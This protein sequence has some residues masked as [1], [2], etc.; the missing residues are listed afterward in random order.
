MYEVTCFHCVNSV[1]I[2]PDASLCPECGEDLQHLLA[3]EAVVHYFQTRAH[4]LSTQGQLTTALAEAER[5]LTFVPASELRLLAAILAKQLGR[6]DR[7][8]QHVAAIP[9]DDSLRGEA[10]WL[11]RSHQDPQRALREAQSVTH[12][13]PRSVDAAP[14]PAGTF[15]EDLL[16]RKQETPA[17]STGAGPTLLALAVAAVALAL[18]VASWW[19]IGPGALPKQTAEIEEAAGVLPTPAPTL[20]A[21]PANPAAAP[22]AVAT[23]SLLPTP[24]PNPAPTLP[25]DVVV[26]PQAQPAEVASAGPRPV[27]VIEADTFDLVGYLREAGQPD[28]AALPVEARRVGDTLVIQGFVQLDLQR[29]TLIQ[30]MEAAPGVSQ[31]NAV[32]LLVRPAPTYVVQDGDT[33]W[34]IVYNIYGNVDRLDEFAAANRDL[35]P[36]PDALAPGLE[37]IVLPIQ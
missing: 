3:A 9:V 16:G 10:E 21:P 7:M 35:L 15:L 34:S 31:V 30:L 22:A 6:A 23:P 36:A 20:T 18:V 4:A 19:W 8:R 24:T 32:D 33:L 17:V 5:G 1:L 25:N 11:L 37:L 2:S 14:T 29:R 12:A 28:L 26:A 13:R 27:L